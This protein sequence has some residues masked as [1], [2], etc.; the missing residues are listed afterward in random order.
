MGASANKHLLSSGEFSYWRFW[1][2]VLISIVDG[3]FACMV[4]RYSIVVSHV[5]RYT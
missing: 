3:R 2:L 4:V 5:Y 1:L